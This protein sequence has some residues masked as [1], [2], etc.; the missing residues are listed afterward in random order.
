MIQTKIF[1]GCLLTPDLKLHLTQSQSWKQAAIGRLPES[2]DLIETH[3]QEKDYLGIFIPHDK[4]TVLDL[5]KVEVLVKDKFF[6]YCP[7][8]GNPPLKIY[9]FPQVFVA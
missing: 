4:P 5:K 9:I 7:E 2:E 8:L 1:V 3:F 6:S